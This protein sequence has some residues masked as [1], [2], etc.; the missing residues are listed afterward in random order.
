MIESVVKKYV[1]ALAGDAHH[2]SILS[3]Y[4]ADIHR[5]HNRWQRLVSESRCNRSPG[6][7][8]CSFVRRSGLRLKLQRL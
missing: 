2:A 5:L 8:S 1:R 7:P 3:I 4:D 6:E